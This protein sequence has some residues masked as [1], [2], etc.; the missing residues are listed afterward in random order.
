MTTSAYRALERRRRLIDNVTRIMY[1]LRII[2][3]FGCEHRSA[4]VPHAGAGARLRR[5]RSAGRAPRETRRRRQASHGRRISLAPRV[6]RQ[7]ANWRSGKSNPTWNPIYCQSIIC[8]GR[9]TGGA[10]G[11]ERP[12]RAAQLI[13]QLSRRIGKTNPMRET[14]ARPGSCGLVGRGRRCWPP[15]LPRAERRA[16]ETAKQTR[17]REIQYHQRLFRDRQFTL[18]ECAALTSL[19]TGALCCALPR[20]GNEMRP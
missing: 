9:F 10:V 19:R 12:P 16:G 1:A 17:H 6:D 2:G 15:A 3:K 20:A 18:A 5:D 4:R 13:G 14:V 7:A 11:H 8:E